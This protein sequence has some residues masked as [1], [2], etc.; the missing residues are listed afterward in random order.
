VLGGLI[1]VLLVFLLEDR[2]REDL[3]DLPV[4]DVDQHHRIVI[5]V[6][7]AASWD[8]YRAVLWGY[9]NFGCRHRQTR[10]VEIHR[11]LYNQ[12]GAADV[13]VVVALEAAGNGPLYRQGHRRAAAAREKG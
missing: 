2:L 6:A 12:P 4:A 10:L 9:F 7:V 11:A 8:D 5:T 3:E 13:G 1:V